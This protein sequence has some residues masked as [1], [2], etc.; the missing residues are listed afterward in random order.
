[1]LL[2]GLLLRAGLLLLLSG[3]GGLEGD[4]VG[5]EAGR[6]GGVGLAFVG[7]EG[8]GGGGEDEGTAAFYSLKLEEGLFL[9]VSAVADVGDQWI[10]GCLGGCL[11]LQSKKGST[12]KLAVFRFASQ[13][14][15][16]QPASTIET[17][18]H[19]RHHPCH[20]DQP[21]PSQQC[22]QEPTEHIS[23]QQRPTSPG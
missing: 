17:D 20:N 6:F 23:H 15:L 5:V 14:S 3:M 2:E 8:L 12:L 4:G 16:H 22:Q 10:R 7:R 18:N 9:F 11:E 1:M 13:D 21:Q 19:H